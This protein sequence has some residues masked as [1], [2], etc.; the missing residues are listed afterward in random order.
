MI[1][2]LVQLGY[3]PIVGDSITGD[4]PLFIKYNDC[5]MIDI[6]PIS[7]LVDESKIEIDA[8]GREYDNSYKDYKVLCRS[9]WCEPKYL[10]RHKTNKD[11]YRI[12]NDNGYVDLTEDHSLFTEDKVKIKPSKITSETKLEHNSHNDIYT[13]FN[14]DDGTEESTRLLAKIVAHGFNVDRIPCNILNASI[15]GKKI[16][17]DEFNKHYNIKNPTKT[18]L[19]GIN[20]L[21]MCVNQ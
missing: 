17:L 21:K 8:L 18:M 14:T 11:I 19:A 7:E 13:D 1:Y 16:F 10:Y 12:S 3:K 2:R 5:D 6:K 9:G 20:Y 15:G 4:T